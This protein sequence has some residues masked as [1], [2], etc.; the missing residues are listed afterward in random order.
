ML[1]CCLALLIL[2]IVLIRQR[3]FCIIQPL[4]WPFW[5]VENYT[6]FDQ[7]HTMTI[8]IGRV[9]KREWDVKDNCT[10]H[11]SLEQAANDV[12]YVDMT[13]AKITY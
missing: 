1:H 8:L 13:Y 2:L 10:M 3:F 12:Q 5:V 7:H 11:W 9:C 6:K 4:I